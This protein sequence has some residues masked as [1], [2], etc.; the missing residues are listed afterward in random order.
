VFGKGAAVSVRLAAFLGL[1]IFV[2]LVATFSVITTQR[3]TALSRLGPDSADWATTTALYTVSNTRDVNG[4]STM[5]ISIFKSGSRPTANVALV[6]IMQGCGCTAGGS[7]QSQGTGKARFAVSGGATYGPWG[8]GNGSQIVVL[9]TIDNWVQN[10]SGWSIHVQITLVNPAQSSDNSNHMNFKLAVSTGYIVGPDGGYT[11]GVEQGPNT[12]CINSSGVSCAPT[13]TY[14]VPFAPDCAITTAQSVSVILHDMDQGL[15]AV[16]PQHMGVEVRDMTTGVTMAAN[17]YGRGGQLNETGWE[18]NGNNARFYFVAQPAHKYEVIMTSVNGNNVLQMYLPYDSVNYSV[19]CRPVGQIVDASS[20]GC[21]LIRGWMYDNNTPSTQLTFYVLTNPPTAA[22]SYPGTAPRTDARFAGPFKAAANNPPGTP[23]GVPAAHGYSIG[24]PANVQGHGYNGPWVSNVYYIYAADT[25][26]GTL[27]KIDGIAQ[28]ACATLACGTSTFA[29]SIVGQ[30]TTFVVRMNSNV[31]AKT[32]LPDPDFSVT[33]TGPSGASYTAAATLGGTTITSS[34]IQFTPTAPGVYNMTWVYN[35][36]TCSDT[37]NRVGYAPYFNAAGGDVSVGN[38][39][40]KGGACVG[41][42]S[43]EIKALNQDNNPA[44]Q[45]GG[46]NS[47]LGAFATANNGISH[48]T[49]GSTLTPSVFTASQGHGLSFANYDGAAYVTTPTYGDSFGPATNLPC[50][51]DYQADAPV[52]TRA[53]LG[54]GTISDAQLAGAVAAGG[55]YQ[56]PGASITIGTGSDIHL[57]GGKKMTL[58]VTGDVYIASNI[59]YDYAQVTDIPQFR[60]VVTGNIYVSP[61]V[62][63]IHGIYIA[64]SSGG[65][66]GDFVTCAAS[67]GV[68]TSAYA[69]CNKQLKVVGA[70]ATEDTVTLGRTYSSMLP[71]PPVINTAEPAETFQYSPELWLNPKLGSGG[72]LTYQAFTGLPPVL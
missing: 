67:I 39:F 60:L 29:P 48:F 22:D 5:G 72:V 55:D 26:T 20:N 65:T 11:F 3:A 40:Q 24:I 15:P 62:S 66:K 47:G 19:A 68:P 13:F 30:S 49:S 28:A 46:S 44:N 27:Y 71:D 1:G 45:Y 58:Y 18:T 56:A 7:M 16:Q 9:R 31:Y 33:I 37:G 42:D 32:P 64:Q 23:G 4:S 38:G 12:Y 6:A 70:V 41:N 59:Y 51:H 34:N 21:S 14:R 50:V 69:T 57:S 35:G 52:A 8:G 63:E 53:V 2:G 17:L 61:K 36:I 25:S 43:A 54:G 10:G